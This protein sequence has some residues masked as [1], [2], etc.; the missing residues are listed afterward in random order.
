[1]TDV[2]KVLKPSTILTWKLP[3]EFQE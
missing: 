3:R 2:E 1:V